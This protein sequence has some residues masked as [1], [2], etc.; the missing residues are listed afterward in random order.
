MFSDSPIL[1]RSHPQ[2]QTY[3]FRKRIFFLN[4]MGR[5]KSY[6]AHGL[7]VVGNVHLNAKQ[8]TRPASSLWNA[9]T[10][11]LTQSWSWALLEKP[12]VV[13]LLKNFPTFYGTRRFI[14]VFTRA[15]HW[16]LSWARSPSHP[17]SLKSILILFTHLRGLFLLYNRQKYFD[18]VYGFIYTIL[19]INFINCISEYIVDRVCFTSEI[20]E[21]MRVFGAGICSKSC[22][23]N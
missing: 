12:P 13:Q 17:N 7:N 4:Q 11:S 6:K 15:L 1:L 16:S 20:I 22:K 21:W 14:T 18:S 23:A 2:L 3:R 5:A 10:H 9:L 8:F 19:R